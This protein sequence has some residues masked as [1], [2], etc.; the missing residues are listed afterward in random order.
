MLP[1]KRKREI[2]KKIQNEEVVE[3]SKLSEEFSV[4]EIT[5]RKDLNELAERGALKRTHGGAVLNESTVFEPSHDEKALVNI[6]EKKKIGRKAASFIED[7]TTIFLST[8]TTTTQIIDHLGDKKGL[9]VVTNSL[10]NGFELSKLSNINL[11]IVG[12]DFRSKSY[13]LVGPITEESFKHIYVD[14]LFLGVN[15]ISI[16]YGLTTPTVVEAKICQMMIEV[17]KEIIVVA[18]HSKFG[19]VVHGRIGNIN[20]ANIVVTDEGL[21]EELREKFNQVDAELVLAS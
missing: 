12:G 20:T 15:G 11:T 19:K 13:A 14:Q 6:K 2:L 4:S 18:D 8:G 16:E 17:A 5:I 7:N 10:N 3:T 21:S 1:E 9:T